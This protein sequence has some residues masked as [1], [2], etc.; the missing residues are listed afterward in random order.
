MFL[1]GESHRQKSL[2]ATVHEL[3]R[4]GHDLETKPPPQVNVSRKRAKNHIFKKAWSSLLISLVFNSVY[5]RE[6]IAIVRPF[7]K[8]GNQDGRT[9]LPGAEG[10][11]CLCAPSGLWPPGSPAPGVLHGF[12]LQ[13]LLC[14]PPG[15]PPDTRVPSAGVAV[16]SCR[17][18][19]RP[20]GPLCR[21]CGALLGGGL[22]TQG[23]S[24]QGLL[25]G[26]PGRPPDPGVPS[27]GAAVRSSGRGS[28]PGTE[29]LAPAA[30]AL[31]GALPR[32]TSELLDA[33]SPAPGRD[34]SQK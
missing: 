29:P 13:R 20:R 18:G 5:D 33:S 24:L 4:V 19:S 8:G 27:A 28:R 26:P 6:V 7:I 25:C 30:A 14:G 17:G 1:S 2:Q 31:P 32:A 9:G 3:A 15:G 34:K 16:R 22:P 10:P 11:V 12:S 23:F 21:G